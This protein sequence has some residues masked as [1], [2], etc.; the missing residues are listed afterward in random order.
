VERFIGWK[1]IDSN[2]TNSFVDEDSTNMIDSNYNEHK[3]VKVVDAQF[4][5]NDVLG[6]ITSQGLRSLNVANLL[7]M[8]RISS[9]E[10]LWF[11]NP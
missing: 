11:N 5:L 7:M 1:A 3:G 8:K 10:L 4:F 6:F 2:V 9:L